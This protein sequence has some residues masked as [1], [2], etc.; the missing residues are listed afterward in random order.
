MS[1]KPLGL[2][3]NPSARIS[4]CDQGSSPSFLV[5]APIRGASLSSVRVSEESLPGAHAFLRSVLVDGHKDAQIGEQVAAELCRIGLFAAADAM[6]QAVAYQFPLRHRAH[7]GTLLSRASMNEPAARPAHSPALRLP[8]EWSEQSLRFEP[9]HHGS[10]WA[11]VRVAPDAAG[12][13]RDEDE[14]RE[15][16]QPEMALDPEATRTHFDREGFAILENLLPAE[17]VTE[18][19]NYFQALAAQGFLS[20]DEVRGA[21]RHFAHNHPVANFWHDQLNE[22]V[23]QLAGRPTKPSYSFVSLYIAGGDLLWHT[24]RPPCEYT[25]A[26]L[27]DYAPLDGDG[28]SPWALKLKGRDGTI[29][30]LHQRLGEALILKGR[31]LMH[32][33]DVLPEGHHSASLLFHFVNEDHDGELK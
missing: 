26:L 3:L 22:R 30:S 16:R 23:S 8:A 15:A 2:V 20:F 18:L 9:H 13:G 14:R 27:L 11:P 1:P 6:P 17:H 10:V 7:S 24:D 28:R 33:R 4:I 31:E 19:G 5:E 21:R 12:D 32:G 29:H 25:I